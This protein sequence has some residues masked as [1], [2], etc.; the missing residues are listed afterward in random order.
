MN[1]IMRRKLTSQYKITEGTNDPSSPNFIEEGPNMIN[2][3]SSSPTMQ[4]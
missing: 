1:H 2:A 3:K 4:H